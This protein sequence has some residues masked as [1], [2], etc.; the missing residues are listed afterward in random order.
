MVSLTVRDWQFNDTDF[1]VRRRGSSG[2]G[3]TRISG[4]CPALRDRRQGGLGK[5]VLPVALTCPVLGRELPYE[6]EFCRFDVF[7]ASS[8]DLS[9]LRSSAN[10]S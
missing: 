6:I 10:G 5:V 9:F 4:C 3:Q 7:L 1:L 2:D 8:R